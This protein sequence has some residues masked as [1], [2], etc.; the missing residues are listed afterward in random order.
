MPMLHFLADPPP[1]HRVEASTDPSVLILCDHAS[2]LIPERYGDLGLDAT[3]L[4]DH[5]AWDIGAEAVSRHLAQRLG[6]HAILAGISRLVIDL[7]RPLG[8]PSSIPARTCGVEV[9][10]NRA[11]D[12][13]QAEA[14]AEAWFWPYHHEVTTQL[15]RMFRHG[16]VPAVISIHSFTPTLQGFRRPWEIGVLWNRDGRMALPVLDSLSA[17]PGLTVG[18]NQPYSARE[19]NYTL[20]THAGAA[21]L[22]HISFEIRQDVLADDAACKRWGDLLADVLVPVLAQPALRRVQVF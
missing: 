19:I 18:D 20:D 21:G 1:F 9:P 6:C 4:A 22:P 17:I 14:R 16:A 15:G 8:E 13:D 11:I 3:T 5:V 10:G 7:N 2:A 12:D